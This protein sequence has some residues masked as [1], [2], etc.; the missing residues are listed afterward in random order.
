MIQRTQ[1]RR[2]DRASVGRSGFWAGLGRFGPFLGSALWLLIVGAALASPPVLAGTPRNVLVLLSYDRLLPGNL[3]GDRALR[4]GFA[5]RP[6]LPVSISV[7][8]LENVRFSGEA[9]ERTFVTYLRDKYVQRPPEVVIVAA[10][11]AFDFVL[12]HRT[13]LFPRVPIVHVSVQDKHLQSIAALPADVIGTPIAHDFIG[14]VTQ[15]LRWHPAARRLVIVTGFSP[16]DREW[17]A[18]LRAQARDLPRELS[19]EFMA[20]LPTTELQRRLRALQ[21][22]SIVYTPGYFKDGSGREFVPRD[23]ARVIAAAAPVPVYGPF[24]S[25]MNTGIVGGRMADYTAI[26]LAGARTAI[27]LLEGA[28][29]ATIVQ[30]KTSPTPWQLDWR[31]MKRWGISDAAV[32]ADA[33]IRFRPPSLWEA[34]RDLVIAGIAVIAVQASLI[35]ALLLERR[36]RRRTV[37]ELARS[38]QLIRL[39]AEAAHLSTWVLDGHSIDADRG[40]TTHG[41]TPVARGP[42]ADFNETRARISPLDRAAVDTALRNA[43]A[44]AADFDVEYRV[45][46]PNGEWG[47]QSARGRAD[48]AAVPRLLGVAMDI[49]QRKRAEAQ[50]AQDRADLYHM[51]RVSLLGQLSA[52]IAH[53]LNQPLASILSNAEA[54]QTMLEREPLD[55][56]ELRAICADIVAEDQRAAQVIRR[57]GLLFKRGEAVLEPLDANELA[58]DTFEFTRTVLTR[59]HVAVSMQLEPD[60]PLI[61]GDR[62]QLQQLL[63]NLMLNAADAMGDLPENR[64]QMSIFTSLQAG[65][66]KISVIDRGP[67]VPAEAV[68]KVFEPFWSTRPGGMGMGL[69]VCRS[70]VE[71]H[72]GHLTVSPAAE[73]GAVFCVSLPVRS[74]P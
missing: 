70:I 22:S 33:I 28:D 11:E 63:L 57:L 61:A 2:D 72:H 56:D 55:V 24:S 68:D 47:W 7:E 10:D 14:T 20:G 64:R 60:L 17:E 71:A 30:P 45:E 6:D 18:R 13:E 49:T 19:I 26:G 3:E 51:T 29:P 9:Y 15:A 46:N 41:K 50:A 1:S 52:A 66:V 58:R 34:Y 25:F 73:G 44:T 74:S 67:G 53:Q 5:A 54:A 12:R 38:E 40:G 48:R 59:R 21:S 42:L 36:R 62:I 16:W 37:A 32:P 65:N 69:A 27:A 43:L 4:D 8:Y 35:I 23:A 31:Q 39:A